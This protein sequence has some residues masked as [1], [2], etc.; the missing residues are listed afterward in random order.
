MKAVSASVTRCLQVGSRLRCIDNTG[1]D[2]VEIIAVKKY[3]GVKRRKPMAGV[4]DL[5]SVAVKKGDPKIRHEVVD[6]VIVRQRKEY[7]RMNGMRVSFEDNACVLVNEKGDVKGTRVK[8]PVAKEAVER[9]S[10]IAKISTM[11]V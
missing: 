7:R 11:V 3:K 8:G 9:F 6:A 10:G 4:A 5:V 1:A 2:I